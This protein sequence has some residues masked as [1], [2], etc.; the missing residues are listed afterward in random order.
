MVSFVE[1][2]SSTGL[3]TP[4]L[5]HHKPNLRLYYAAASEAVFIWVRCVQLRVEHL[6]LRGVK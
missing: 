1:C 6:Q 2:Q 5:D 3:V 4:P